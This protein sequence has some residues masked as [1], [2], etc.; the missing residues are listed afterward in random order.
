VSENLPRGPAA[1]GFQFFTRRQMFST[2]SG[3]M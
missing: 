1:R 2:I 3:R